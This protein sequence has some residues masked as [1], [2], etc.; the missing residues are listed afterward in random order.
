MKE[1]VESFT[2]PLWLVVAVITAW[3]AWTVKQRKISTD[4]K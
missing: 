1:L 3:G 2:T 4:R